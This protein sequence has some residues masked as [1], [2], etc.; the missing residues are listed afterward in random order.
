MTRNR[1]W[2]SPEIRYCFFF[3]SFNKVRRVTGPW[4]FYRGEDV[5]FF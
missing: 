1:V 3:L 4:P 2:L 5:N